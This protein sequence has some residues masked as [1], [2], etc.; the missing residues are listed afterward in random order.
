MYDGHYDEFV[1]KICKPHSAQYPV[2]MT[3]G[4]LHVFQSFPN[5]LGMD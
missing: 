2:H 3:E 5:N 4:V 1:N